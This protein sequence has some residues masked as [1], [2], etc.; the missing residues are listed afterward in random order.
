MLF[1]TWELAYLIADE[2]LRDWVPAGVFTRQWIIY[3]SIAFTLAIASVIVTT[4]FAFTFGQFGKTINRAFLWYGTLLLISTTAIFIIDCLPEVFAGFI[5][6]GVFAFAIYILQKKYF[7]KERIIKNRLE[8]G[9]AE[10]NEES[11]Y[12]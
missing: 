8:K 12:V 10:F 1:A 11:L 5:G 2:W 7:T 6:A 9:K 3:Y 4:R